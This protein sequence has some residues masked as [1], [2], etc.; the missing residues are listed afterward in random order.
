MKKREESQESKEAQALNR[1]LYLNPY[2][3]EQRRGLVIKAEKNRSDRSTMA[4][5]MSLE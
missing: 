2:Q 1:S 4:F 5:G 3:L